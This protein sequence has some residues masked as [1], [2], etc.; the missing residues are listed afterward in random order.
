MVKVITRRRAR[1][2]KNRRTCDTCSMAEDVLTLKVCV[3]LVQGYTPEFDW[4][5]AKPKLNDQGVQSV[6]NI[7][8]RIWEGGGIEFKAKVYSPKTKYRGDVYSGGRMDE[9]ERLFDTDSNCM[10]SIGDVN[11]FVVPQIPE[12]VYGYWT[13]TDGKEFIV[14]GEYLEGARSKAGLANTFAHELGHWLG[15]FH[16][17]EMDNLMGEFGD[18]YETQIELNPN[19]VRTARENALAIIKMRRLPSRMKRRIRKRAGD[20]FI[21]YFRSTPGG[22]VIRIK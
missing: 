19:Q 3:H 16:T 8:N 6:F 14:I 15:L 10:R 9:I 22:R 2:K 4:G 21:P 11:V 18:E 17:N 7:V 1:R 13:R 12:G 5:V 20:V